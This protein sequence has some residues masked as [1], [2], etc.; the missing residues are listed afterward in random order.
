M[1]GFQWYAYQQVLT[2]HKE[3]VRKANIPRLIFKWRVHQALQEFIQPD[4]MS[5][6]SSH[7]LHSIV[8]R[9]YDSADRLEQGI[10][11]QLKKQK[12]LY[13]V[14]E[15][16]ADLFSN[17]MVYRGQCQRGCENMCTCP[18]NWLAAW[19]QGRSLDIEKYIAHKDKEVSAFTLQQTQELERWQRWLWQQHF[20]EDFM[21]MQQIDE[22]FWQEL[23]HPERQKKALSRLPQQIVIFTLLDLPPSQLQFLRRLGNTSMF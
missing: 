7:P 9:I 4:V 23:E 8:Q 2:A 6:D 15:Q 18:N 19:G 17:Y 11:K 22:L 13:W 21:Q 16:V 5:I 10:E 3:Q 12:M 1:R 14:A 20:H